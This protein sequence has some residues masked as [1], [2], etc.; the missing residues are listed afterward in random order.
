[1]ANNWLRGDLNSIKLH[2]ATTHN[3]IRVDLVFTSAAPP[4]RVGGS[5]AWYFHVADPNQCLDNTNALCY[6]SW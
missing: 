2:V 4:T 1:M 3:G 5:G 6:S